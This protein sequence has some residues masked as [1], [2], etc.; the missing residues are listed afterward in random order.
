MSGLASVQAA[1]RHGVPVVQTFHA[2]G[3]VK[4]RWQ[5]D[6]DTSPASRLE[7][8]RE[9][10]CRA[11]RVI[12]TCSDEAAELRALGVPSD[13]VDVVPCGVDVSLFRPAGRQ[14]RSAGRAPRLLI[15][16]R[17]VPRKGV[18]DAIRA[19]A[20]VPEAELVIVGGPAADRL[21]ADPEVARLRQ[22]A[23]ECGV[24]DRVLLTGHR[25]A[26]RTAGDDPVQRR[27]AGGAVVRAVRH[28]GAGGDGLRRAGGR[29]GGRRPAG[30][31]RSR[32][33][34]PAGDQP[35]PAQIAAATG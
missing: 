30:H 8:E 29:L 20:L 25:R 26:R 34:R 23:A 17:L 11:D 15:V 9:V 27:P 21:D 14:D 35:R 12:A 6:Q 3:V 24:A 22:V 16:G 5:G 2:L 28:H 13:R 33:D 7:I 4:R 18:E 31:G 32:G 1:A 19:L 10:A